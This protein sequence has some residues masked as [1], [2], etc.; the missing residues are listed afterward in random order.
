MNESATT[1]RLNG[2]LKSLYSW[3]ND[4]HN[5]PRVSI[6][7]VPNIQFVPITFIYL[8]VC[9]WANFVLNSS[10]EKNIWYLIS[11]VVR[12]FKNNQYLFWRTPQL[13]LNHNRA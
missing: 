1:P 4:L 5:S 8:Q 12:E 2:A 3:F 11:I 9:Q 6:I 10:I 13:S 7:T